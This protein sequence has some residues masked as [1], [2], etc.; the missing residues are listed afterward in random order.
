MSFRPS[1]GSGRS[2]IDGTWARDPDFVMRFE[3][4]SPKCPFRHSYADQPTLRG[5]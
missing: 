2:A 5:I 4:V 1:L 3:S